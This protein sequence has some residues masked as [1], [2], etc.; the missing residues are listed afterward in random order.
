MEG[1]L[2]QFPA[3]EEGEAMEQVEDVAGDD[4]RE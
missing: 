3:E 1:I 2:D 4:S